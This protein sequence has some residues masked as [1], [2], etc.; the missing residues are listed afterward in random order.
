VNGRAPAGALSLVIR[1][2]VV[3]VVCS[4]CLL[5]A[6]LTWVALARPPGLELLVAWFAALALAGAF[7]PGLAN[8]ITLSRAHLAGP[9][10]VYSLL[11]GRLVELAAVVGLAGLSD[12]VDGTVARRLGGPSRL[13]GALDP[14][15]DGVLFGAVA[16][17]LSAGGLYP[18]WLALV[19]VARYA[20][21]A[22]AGASLILAGR[23]PALR[24]TPLGQAST[25]LVAVLLGALALARG[26][27]WDVGGLLTASEVLVPLAALLTFANLVAANRRAI[28]GRGEG[29]R[30]R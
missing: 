13:G 22:L 18:L 19:V 7:V 30:R 9:A 23:R 21:P 6:D 25:A 29:S 11:P 10:V 24:H 12:V 26:L 5:A 20:V 27:G 16:V 8:Q 17:A 15:M 28:L 2:S 14:V 3:G 1:P 4:G